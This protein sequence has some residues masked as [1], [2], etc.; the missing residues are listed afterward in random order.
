MPCSSWDVP[1]SELSTLAVPATCVGM[2][3]VG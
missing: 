2:I 3:L 1:E